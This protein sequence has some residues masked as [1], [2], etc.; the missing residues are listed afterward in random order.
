MR[1]FAVITLAQEKHR[2]S[3]DVRCSIFKMKTRTLLIALAL[4]LPAFAE[5]KPAAPAETPPAKIYAP[6][7][8]VA[9][10]ATD[11]KPVTVEG[12][13]VVQGE[14]KTATVRYLNFTKNYKESLSLIF[15]VDK[16]GEE[17]SKEKLGAF[18]GKKVRVT[19]VVTS[20]REALQIKIDKLDQIKVQP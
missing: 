11:D 5:D 16:G 8:L 19:G 18:V 10:K 20:F 1:R 15:M 3:H 13:I 4:T 17:F 14:N 7:D 9:L 2:V 6:T 12:K